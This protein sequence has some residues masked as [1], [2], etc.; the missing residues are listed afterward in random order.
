[1]K[2]NSVIR[3]A[4]KVKWER[5]GKFTMPYLMAYLIS[6][7]MA[8]PHLSPLGFKEIF[9]SWLFIDGEEWWDSRDYQNI[10]KRLE[11]LL[12]KKDTSF[13]LDFLYFN[14]RE[15]QEA[16]EDVNSLTASLV[17]SLNNKELA[18]L[19]HSWFTAISVIIHLNV[20]FIPLDEAI[21]SIM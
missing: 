6:E 14:E 9:K 20:I 17:D 13:L 19:F 2:F 10:L 1:M 21:E 8:T 4:K 5:C 12:H 16:L 3:Q 15:T 18:T 11:K 7:V